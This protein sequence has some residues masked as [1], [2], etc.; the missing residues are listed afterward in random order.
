MFAGGG[1]AGGQ[2]YGAT[3]P[4]GMEVVDGKATEGDV[5]VTLCSALGIE[6]D[7]ENI[8]PMGRPHKIAE[9]NPIR[10]ILS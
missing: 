6:A 2:A 3:S 10:Q 1:V 4:D 8:S 7:A 5:L 9:G